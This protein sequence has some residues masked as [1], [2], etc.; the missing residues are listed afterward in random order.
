MRK[1]QGSTGVAPIQ[2][3]NPKRDKWCV[4]WNIIESEDG[5]TAEYMEEEFSH[6]PTQDEI[7]QLLVK[8]HNEQID[9]RILTGYEWRGMA[10]WLSSENQFNYKAA[11]D[12]AMQTN[13]ATLPVTFKFGA[14]NAPQYHEFADLQELTEFFVG[15][16]QHVQTALA[17]GWT[18]KDTINLEPYA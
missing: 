7:K 4:R 16:M 9:Y 14:D 3:V 8:W 18:A 5:T 15:A 11:Y 17:E 12:L 2:C 6:R 1:V 10:V 13:G